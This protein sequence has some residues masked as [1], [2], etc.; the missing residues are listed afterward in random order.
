MYAASYSPIRE[1][2]RNQIYSPTCRFR[3]SEPANGKE[4]QTR[5]E[6]M[7]NR[8]SPERMNH[9]MDHYRNWKKDQ[10]R[11]RAVTIQIAEGLIIGFC[12]V[13]LLFA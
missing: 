3:V 4:F 2:T 13:V 5:D 7:T 9:L 11:K 10:E 1:E 12:I 6:N 8:L